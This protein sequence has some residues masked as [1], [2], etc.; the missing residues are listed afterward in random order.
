[1]K[2]NIF[3]FRK[4]IPKI[5]EKTKYIILI[6]MGILSFI[7]LLFSV[8]NGCDYHLVKSFMGG[9]VRWLNELLEEIFNGANLS[10]E[11]IEDHDL[12][13]Y[14]YLSYLGKFLGIRDAEQLFLVLQMLAYG[15]VLLIYPALWYYLTETWLAGLSTPIFIVLILRPMLWTFCNDSYWAMAWT[16]LIGIPLIAAFYKSYGEKKS[17]FFGCSICVVIALGN[18]PRGHSS[19]GITIVFLAILLKVFIARYRADVKKIGIKILLNIIMIIFSYQCFTNI[20]PNIYMKFSG[21]SIIMENS[22]AWHT[23]Y[24]GLGWEEN[25]Y[26]I[27]WSDECGT[28]AARRI[29][30]NVIHNTKEYHEIIKQVYL[31]LVREDPLFIVQSYSRKLIA[32]IKISI[33][34]IL[35]SPYFL[36]KKVLVCLIFLLLLFNKFVLKRQRQFKEYGVLLTGTIFCGI[37]SLIFPMIATIGDPYLTG[38]FAAVDLILFILV[39]V[40]VA[41]FRNAILKYIEG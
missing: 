25:K 17:L 2:T 1:M 24:V 14:L 35:K 38:S 36:F 19:M 40:G 15:G 16:V 30:P 29:K 6:G 34:Y 12:T 37:Q 32:C 39:M 31:S 28:E 18:I 21:Q 5:S 20:V 11:K 7:V 9:R 4:Y 33:K 8:R 22:P 23:L 10:L 13:Y 3:C 41:N 26:G 27:I